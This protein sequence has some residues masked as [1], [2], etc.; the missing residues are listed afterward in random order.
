MYKV[1]LL[2]GKIFSHFHIVWALKFINLICSIFERKIV[3]YR[4]NKMLNLF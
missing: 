4:L 3:F 2:I 1:Y